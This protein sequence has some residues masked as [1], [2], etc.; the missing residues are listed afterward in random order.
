[1]STLFFSVLIYEVYQYILFHLILMFKT[2]DFIFLYKSICMCST[3]TLILVE[4][5]I[6]Q[7]NE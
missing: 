2:K 6:G 7:I 4:R 1:M 5:D 3:S